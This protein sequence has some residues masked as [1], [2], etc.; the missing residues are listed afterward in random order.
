[1]VQFILVKMGYFK[2]AVCQQA[3]HH[4]QVQLTL[5]QV[6]VK[7][8]I[9][10][11]DVYRSGSIMALNCGQRPFSY[12]PPAGFKT[13]CT[14]NLSTPTIGTTASTTANEYF[15]ATTYTG[16]GSSL[17]I[18]NS[19]AMQPDLVWIKIRNQAFD[20]TLVDAV[21]GTSKDLESNTTGSE[22]TRSTVTGV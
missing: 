5:G 1:M 21:R 18:T 2:I 12:T 6:V 11:M 8:L 20:H 14:T 22:Q 17:S 16:T 13:L 4:A 7:I 10:Q 9:P 3:V 15:D 19:G